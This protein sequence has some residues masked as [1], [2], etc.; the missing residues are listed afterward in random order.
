MNHLAPAAVN[1]SKLSH[2]FCTDSSMGEFEYEES[3]SPEKPSEV[4]ISNADQL[5]L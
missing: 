2:S 3:L 4:I 5:A 1:K